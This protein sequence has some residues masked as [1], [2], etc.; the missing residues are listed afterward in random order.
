MAKHILAHP[1]YYFRNKGVLID[2]KEAGFL[3]KILYL[4]PFKNYIKIN[5][6]IIN[7]ADLNFQ[8]WIEHSKTWKIKTLKYPMLCIINIVC[9]SEEKLW[10]GIFKVRLLKSINGYY[11]CLKCAV[12]TM[13]W[14]IVWVT[15]WII[16]SM[17][18]VK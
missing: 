13:L 16:L 11:L 6:S 4:K 17:Y 10:H 15:M 2:D 1:C 12:Q 14:V 9:Y 3:Y 8:R 18:S 7:G 5:K